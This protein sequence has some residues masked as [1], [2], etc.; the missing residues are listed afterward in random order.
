MSA[1]GSVSTALAVACQAF[2]RRG[3]MIETF[4]APHDNPRPA[5]KL[6]HRAVDVPVIAVRAVI[7]GTEMF[8]DI[9]LYGLARGDVVARL[10]ETARW[11]F[12]ARYVPLGADRVQRVRMRATRIMEPPKSPCF[13]G[14]G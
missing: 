13:S 1:E 11:H 9:V 14:F 6:G 2:A 8:E 4:M 7:A 12:L 10:P 3:G 5:N